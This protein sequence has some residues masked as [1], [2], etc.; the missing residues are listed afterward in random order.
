MKT[1]YIDIDTETNNIDISLS[2]G[3]K[4]AATVNDLAQARMNGDYLAAP[5]EWGEC[6]IG[7]ELSAAAAKQQHLCHSDRQIDAV[8]FELNWGSLRGEIIAA[9]KAAYAE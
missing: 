3:S 2:D 8:A 4:I 9:I 7:P 5:G 6:E 1:K